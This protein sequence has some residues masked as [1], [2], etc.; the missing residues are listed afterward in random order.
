M[1]QD[2]LLDAGRKFDGL[3]IWSNQPEG[4]GYWRDVASRLRSK[5]NGSRSSN[6][7]PVPP[8]GDGKHIG[9]AKSYARTVYD[10]VCTMG[11]AACQPEGCI[12]W[13]GVQ[14]RLFEMLDGTGVA[15]ALHKSKLLLLEKGDRSL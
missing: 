3:M 10:A 9:V 6:T 12:Y 15:P 14:R 4:H 1:S 7:T 11:D 5:G 2:K 8:V 13:M